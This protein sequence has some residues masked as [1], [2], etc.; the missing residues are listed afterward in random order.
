M[1]RWFFAFLLPLKFRIPC[2]APSFSFSFSFSLSFNLCLT[3]KTH[4]SSINSFLFLPQPDFNPKDVQK[5]GKN[6]QF[7]PTHRYNL[8]VITSFPHFLYNFLIWA[9]EFLVAHM[10]WTRKREINCVFA[11]LDVRMNCFSMVVWYFI[12]FFFFLCVYVKTTIGVALL[13]Q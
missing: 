13:I 11:S 10:K 4:C 12:C 3:N 9:L 1:A 7:L 2:N 6:R 5:G 8:Y